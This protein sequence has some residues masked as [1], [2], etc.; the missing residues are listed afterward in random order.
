MRKESE[1]YR[2]GLMVWGLHR[3]AL[4]AMVLRALGLRPL[5]GQGHLEEAHPMA[6][7][8]PTAFCSVVF[9]PKN[10]YHES[11]LFGVLGIGLRVSGPGIDSY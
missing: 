11:L 7:N 3:R 4:R 8:S 9:G 10:L 1:L 6:Q 5:H 2:V